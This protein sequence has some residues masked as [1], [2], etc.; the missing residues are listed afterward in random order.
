MSAPGWQNL[1][2]TTSLGGNVGTV[3]E[4]DLVAKASDNVIESLTRSLKVVGGLL[5]KA[6]D[7]KQAPPEMHEVFEAGCAV[8]ELAE[9][10]DHVLIINSNAHFAQLSLARGLT[11]AGQPIKQQEA[12]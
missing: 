5:W 2:I 11:A 12:A 7:N 1:L 6:A 4:A 3:E 10:L 9:L 8:T